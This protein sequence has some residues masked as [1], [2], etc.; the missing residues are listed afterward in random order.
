MT[1]NT[2]IDDEQ[3]NQ[4]MEPKQIAG[5]NQRPI[6]QDPSNDPAE[7]NDSLHPMQHVQAEQQLHDDQPSDVKVDEPNQTREAKS[8]KQSL[9]I[10]PNEM[11]GSVP[12][13]NAG[14]PSF[15]QEELGELQ[16]RW[17]AIQV[18]FVD[19]P[20]SAVEQ[21]E[22]FVAETSERVKQML[23]DKQKVLGQQWLNHDEVT[24]EELRVIM[25]D[26]RTL[27]NQMLKL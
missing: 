8:V 19:E 23:V 21:A 7:E 1:E 10:N 27:L 11:P 24:T 22:A 4:M 25:Q 20:C 26:Y 2:P 5:G 13:N 14:L 18:Q 3:S 17:K 9:A 15:S 12:G 6:N 16:S